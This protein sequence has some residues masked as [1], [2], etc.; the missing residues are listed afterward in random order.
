MRLGFYQLIS[1]RQIFPLI[2]QYAQNFSDQRIA[3]LGDTTL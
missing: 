3:L 2:A 1:E